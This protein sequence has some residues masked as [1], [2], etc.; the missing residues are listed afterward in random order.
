VDLFVHVNVAVQPLLYQVATAGLSPTDI[1]SPIRAVMREA[2]NVNVVPLKVSTID[3][4][5][6]E[7]GAE[8]RPIAFDR[9]IV[10]TGAQDA[11]STLR[12]LHTR[13]PLSGS[14]RGALAV[15]AAANVRQA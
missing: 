10:A 2:R 13:N 14:E 11:L 4:E 6:R 8:G 9:L 3:V 7:V 1:A 12:A 15:E 5:R